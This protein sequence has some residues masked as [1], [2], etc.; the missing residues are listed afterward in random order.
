MGLAL[1]LHGL[2]ASSPSAAAVVESSGMLACSV[3]PSTSAFEEHAW[4][5]VLVY[6]QSAMIG[7]T[8]KHVPD[9]CATAAALARTPTTRRLRSK[10]FSTGCCC[11]L[12]GG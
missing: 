10:V 6:M 4:L 8:L 1:L 3:C 5:Y 7:L 11:C 2:A 9:D 12:P